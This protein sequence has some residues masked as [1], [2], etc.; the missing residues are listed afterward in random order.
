MVSF[1]LSSDS[2]RMY[3]NGN[4]VLN[5]YYFSPLEQISE[6]VKIG[7]M[8]EVNGANWFFDGKIDDI[9]IW[10]RALSAEEIQQLYMINACTFTIYDTVTV[11]EIIYDTVLLSTTDTLII[12]TLIT[13]TE[14]A[15]ENT[16]LVYPNPANTQITINNGNFGILAGYELKITNSLGQNVYNEEITQQEVTLDISTWGGNGL[17]ILY[18]NEPNGNTIAVKQIV[19]Q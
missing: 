10:N 12:E 17:Y 9:G 4:E 6:P 13:S 16:F 11:T 5:E 3:V 18:I 1:T 15:L 7:V 19:L 14:P 2:L 8:D